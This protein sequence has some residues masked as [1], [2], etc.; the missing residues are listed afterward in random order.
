MKFRIRGMIGG[1]ILTYINQPDQ[2]ETKN[3]TVSIILPIYN[4]ES[5][6]SR[7][8]D[9][10]LK[11]NYKDFELILV[12]DGSR[13]RSGA[14][15]DA[16]ASGDD[17]IHVIHKENTGVSDSR[18]IAISR[19]KGTY[20][21]FVDGDDWIAPEATGLLV[22]AASTHD[23][24]LVISDFYRVIDNRIAHKGDIQEEGLLSREEFASYMLE[25]PADYY[26]GVLW[27]KLYKKSLIDKYCLMMNADI[28]WCEDFMFNLE[29]IC[30]TRNIYVMRIPIYYYVKT[31]NSL[32]SQGT[33]TT[34]FEYYSK[35]FKE[36]FGEKDY[37]KSRL[38]VYRFFFDAASD[39]TVPPSLLP[40]TIRLGEE[41]TQINTKVIEDGSIFLNIYLQR[42]CMESCL[43]TAAQRYDMQIDEAY[44]LLFLSQNQNMHSRKELSDFIG[45]PKRKIDA[46]LQKLKSR[47]YI[48]W[49]Q[50]SA[51]KQ[52]SSSEQHSISEQYSTSEQHSSSKA[53]GN[54]KTNRFLE[55]QILPDAAQ[56]ISDL[57]DAQNNYYQIIYSD[58]SEDEI[59]AFESFSG[60]IKNN[61]T[62][63]LL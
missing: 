47:G 32:S 23:C 31:K 53:E 27:N 1:I 52:H 18:N 44:L 19:A 26:Y 25:K 46:A 49:K 17:R 12:D 21:Q 58:F 48:T 42:K 56:A 57:T 38:Q 28:S 16:Y 36:V 54:K 35:F 51:S 60:R 61:I 37:E 59:M 22:A 62:N 29:Y 63:T 13:D 30:H 40:G 41:R 9:S 20:L 6:I 7:C 11:Q 45:R 3:P 4:A 15:C 39:G 34:V 24:D 2:T 8:I 43:Q 14:I 50:H 5:V 33:S 55:F 10:I